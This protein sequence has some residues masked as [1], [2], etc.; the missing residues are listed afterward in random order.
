MNVLLL[1][2]ALS[3]ERP[4]VVQDPPLSPG[5]QLKK[6]HVPPGFRV[7]LVAAEPDVRKPMNL[8]FDDRGR[9]F[10]THS[11]E[12][13]WPAKPGAVPRDAVRVFEDFG[14]DGRARKATTF[15]DGLNI[16]IGL[17]PVGSGAL[18]HSI[19]KIYRCLDAD[20][21]GRADAREPFYGDFGSADTHGMAASFVRGLDGWVYA[22]HGFH[23]TSK[24]RGGDGHEFTL[25]SGNT[26]RFR[27]DGSRI[28]QYTHGQV[29]P[30]GLSFDARGDLYSSDCHSLPAYLLQ[31][32]GCYPTFEGK[33]DGLGFAP[34]IMSHQ[35][36][37]SA[38]AGAV[39]YAAEHFPP[40]Y[41]GTI[42]VGNP[43]TGRVN[44]DR[45][46][47]QGS[48]FKAV[49]LPD[50]LTC[51]DPWFRPVHL[52][53]G[54]DGALY[55]ADFYNCIIGHYEVPLDHPKRD[56]ERG[57][58]WRVVYG[59]A[60]P[61]PM[62]D[63]TRGSAAELVDLLGDPNF[64]VRLKATNQLVDRF[65]RAAAEPV[66]KAMDHPFRRAH[67]LWV[68]E[69][70]GGLDDGLVG[71][72]AA[73]AEAIV[74]VHLFK[75][76]AERPKWGGEEGTLARAGLKDAD[77]AVRRAAADALGRHPDRA[78]LPPLLELWESGPDAHL[79]HSVRMALRDHLLNLPGLL[80]DL[81]P[82]AKL[83]DVSLGV[84]TPESARYVF[85]SLKKGL[86]G[87]AALHHVARYVDEAG[88]AEAIAFARGLP[89]NPLP[90]VRSVLQALQER[91]VR[92][93]PE[94]SSWAKDAARAGLA[95]DTS[96]AVGEA[97][98][99]VQD[100][101]LA[102]LHAEVAALAERGARGSTRP[103]AIKAIATQDSL[104][105]VPVLAR[106]LGDGAEGAALRQE[107]SQALASVNSPPARRALVEQLKT[108][109]RPLAVHI[110]GGLAASREGGEILL[111]A[112]EEGKAS[113]HLLLDRAVSERLRESGL[114]ERAGKL[115]ADLPP[116]D[117]RIRKLLDARRA[118]YAKVKPDPA[119]G[120][121]VF[122]K[123]CAGCHRLEG[124]GNKVGPELDGI[125]AR[126]LERVLEDVLD[127]NRN[128]DQAFRASILKTADGRVVSGLVVREEG[129]V[130]VIQEAVDKETRLAKKDVEQR[131]LSSLSPM[132]SNFADTI[133]EEEFHALVG[134]LL[135]QRQAP[136]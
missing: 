83:A 134:Y 86:A 123:T 65:G 51:D 14:P 24:L 79:T 44:H 87:P 116:E 112:V 47:P 106:I 119:R 2:L 17:V 73:D 6:F 68:L 128:V 36:G 19:P 108:A 10:V 110:A 107:A 1:V 23:N 18:V 28:E 39:V 4:H 91:G 75:A 135:S 25:R 72:L 71:T 27:V 61:K 52:Q 98:K 93:P 131:V 7:E 42:F 38:I 37:S 66:R 40:A 77:P 48:A 88:L 12:Y 21:D 9:L 15:V 31:R 115:T 30:F 20:G 41:R 100:L 118:A 11:V 70:V 121:K 80:A 64:I 117:D 129:E 90:T 132:P 78:N 113:R 127:P 74:R 34:A 55:I 67:G 76:L 5:E 130:L 109:P 63:L 8:A 49:K 26:F 124:K 59:D 111:A 58:I 56:R 60:A 94:V 82:R 89:G 62:P 3:Q 43:M 53:L 120:L 101:R 33:H 105:A 136:K 29:N 22:T 35:H 122:E 46:E 54:P 126:G 104:H 97:L 69:R 95:R 92:V 16:P 96:Q 84:R 102:G 81:A 99:L 45:L 13:P 125:G 50:L 114:K 103:A 32:G 85:A 57:R 133:P